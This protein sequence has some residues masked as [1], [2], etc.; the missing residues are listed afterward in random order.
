MRRA[1]KATDVGWRDEVRAKWNPRQL[2]IDFAISRAFAL[3]AISGLRII[4]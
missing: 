4:I 3:S 1:L 2:T